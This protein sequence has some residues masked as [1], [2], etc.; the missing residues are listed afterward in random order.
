MK[1]TSLT[2]PSS[3]NTPSGKAAFYICHVLP[4]WLASLTL[5]ADNIRKKFGT[6]LLGDYRF[7]DETESQK[8]KRHARMAKRREKKAAKALEGNFDLELME[9]KAGV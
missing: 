4:E 5:F 9:K 2:E 8:R 6:G 3:L 1:V 7:K